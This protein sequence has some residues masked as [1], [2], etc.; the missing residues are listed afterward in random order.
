MYSL[1]PF[2]ARE[3]RL[4][5]DSKE[6]PVFKYNECRSTRFFRV[7]NSAIFGDSEFAKKFKRILVSLAGVNLHFGE[8]TAFIF[9]RT[10]FS[11]ES[12][13][14]F[15]ENF[16][17]LSACFAAKAVAMGSIHPSKVSK[18]ICWPEQV[19]VASHYATNFSSFSLTKGRKIPPN[20]R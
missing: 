5:P 16:W 4:S 3:W 14:F 17:A 18:P 12:A 7:A 6:S 20:F 15:G 19:S 8:I 13:K 1:K 10:V 2:S 9:A 11:F